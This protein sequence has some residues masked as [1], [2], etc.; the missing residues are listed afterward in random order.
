M[1]FKEVLP[2][3]KLPISEILHLYLEFYYEF[4]HF[5]CFGI[6]DS[7]IWLGDSC[8]FVG[9]FSALDRYLFSIQM[10]EAL[11]KS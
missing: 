2:H 10:S 7:S 9:H 1:L 5:S 6:L 3:V 8:I 4:A 11:W